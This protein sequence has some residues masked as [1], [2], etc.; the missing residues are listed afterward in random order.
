M[1][2]KQNKAKEDLALGSLQ[3]TG[4]PLGWGHTLAQ[5]EGKRTL[6]EM[7]NQRAGVATHQQT[8]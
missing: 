1:N 7:E 5:S 6:R 8:G 4:S 2:S 3:E